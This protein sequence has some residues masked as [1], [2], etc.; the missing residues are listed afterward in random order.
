DA[1]A[2]HADVPT[3]LDVDVRCTLLEGVLPEPIDD[4]DYVLIVRI[5]VAAIAQLDQLFE[6]ARQ[7]NV[8]VRGLL[9]LFHRP[10]ER[11]EFADVATDVLRVGEDEIDPHPDHL[12]ELICPAAHK[13]LA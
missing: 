11:E 7:R 5:E 6:V 1:E 13:G 4:M 10:S 9:R 12:L 8:A 3:R 2:H